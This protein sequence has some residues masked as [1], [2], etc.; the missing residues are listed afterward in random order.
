MGSGEGTGQERI[1]LFW[2]HGSELLFYCFGLKTNVHSCN[3]ESFFKNRFIKQELSRTQ[4]S[5][6]SGAEVIG[7]CES[8]NSSARNQTEI[9]LFS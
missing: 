1:L 5:S 3:G 6:L 4:V 8:P 9:M 7:D 2:A